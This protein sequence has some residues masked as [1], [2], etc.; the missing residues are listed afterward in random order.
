LSRPLR[1]APHQRRRRRRRRAADGGGGAGALSR[2]AA[3][4]E[5]RQSGA[6]ARR[7][8]GRCCAGIA[9]GAARRAWR[10]SLLLSRSRGTPRAPLLLPASSWLAVPRAP[11]SCCCKV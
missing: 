4:R 10:R 7:G 1:R 3:G 11:C 9:V 2:C 8:L 5:L 6:A